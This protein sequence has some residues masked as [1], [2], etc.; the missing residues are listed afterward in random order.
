MEN[1]RKSEPNTKGETYKLSEPV[2]LE[3]TESQIITIEKRM[4][5][6]G[7]VLIPK[8]VRAGRILRTQMFRA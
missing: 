2:G 1:G 4:S 3:N 5:E 8:N 6:L 7:M